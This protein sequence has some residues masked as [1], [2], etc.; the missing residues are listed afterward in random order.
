MMRN[1]ENTLPASIFQSQKN[2]TDL[3]FL[4]NWVNK[5]KRRNTPNVFIKNVLKPSFMK[6][7]H[8]SK[9][10]SYNYVRGINKKQEDAEEFLGIA[11][12]FLKNENI[13]SSLKKANL[14]D[15]TKEQLA[16][17]AQSLGISFDENDDDFMCKLRLLK[18]E[19]CGG[20]IYFN[21]NNDDAQ[22]ETV[23]IIKTPVKKQFDGKK[24]VY[25]KNINSCIAKPDL[26]SYDYYYF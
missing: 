14:N 3:K 15:G 22:N 10:S 11:N 12:A 16:V 24:I 23:Q 17:L 5:K 26:M 25:K 7:E 9:Y 6:S 13:E 2:E 20:R 1:S 21:E 18:E 19:L 8:P 4:L